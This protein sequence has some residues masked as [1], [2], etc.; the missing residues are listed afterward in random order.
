MKRYFFIL[1]IIALSACSSQQTDPN[2]L[3]D[4]IMQAVKGSGAV[5]GGT[6]M[7]EIKQTNMPINMK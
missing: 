4:G 3:P 6:F 5:E 7:P 2:T 1:T